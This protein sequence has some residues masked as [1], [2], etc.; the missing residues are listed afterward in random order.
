MNVIRPFVL[1][2]EDDL[3]TQEMLQIM[4]EER[5][6]SFK[7]VDTCAYALNFLREKKID[8]L[9]LDNLLP[10][11]SGLDLCVQ[12]R[13]FD[14]NLPIIFLSGSSYGDER[15]VALSLGANDFLSKPLEV[16]KLFD[17]LARYAPV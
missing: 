1:C 12:V 17:T 6:Y 13:R 11:G 9:L 15:E 4:L 8:L 3:D 16:K 10:D 7:A 14:K 5:G 2:V